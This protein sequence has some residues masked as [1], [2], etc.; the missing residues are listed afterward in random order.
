MALTLYGS[1]QSRTARVLWMLAELG[2]PFQHVPVAWDDPF[3]KS[4]DFL[5]INPAGRIPAIVDDGVALSESLAIN[6]Y[7]ARK[8]DSPGPRALYPATPED[9]ARTWSWMLWA[10]FDL[11]S[12]LDVIRR[13]RAEIYLPA[14]ERQPAVADEAAGR[15]EP[16]L[17]LLDG[18]LARTPW[19]V[20]DHFSVADLNVAAVLSP[21]RTNLI[22][23]GPCPALRTWLARC[24]AR[25]ACLEARRALQPAP[26][27]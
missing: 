9:E 19:L 21:S 27:S 25:P 26:G 15:L 14:V 7:L 6:L 18:V 20:G 12:P 1:P 8:Y 22:E 17:G 3:L 16:A 23:L 11:E 24:Y 13:H 5:R 10:T 4:A 2:I